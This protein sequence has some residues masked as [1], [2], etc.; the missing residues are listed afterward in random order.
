LRRY[1]SRIRAGG[2]ALPLSAVLRMRLRAAFEIASGTKTGPARSV[3][4]RGV[5]QL[6]YVTKE[7]VR[8]HDSRPDGSSSLRDAAILRAA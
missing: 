2:K 1:T 6:F 3:L 8:S 5:G 7:A 4:A